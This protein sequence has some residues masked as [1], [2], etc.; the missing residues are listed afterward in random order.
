MRSFY[1]R[2]TRTPETDWDEEKGSTPLCQIIKM[3]KRRIKMNKKR[4]EFSN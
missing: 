3:Y 1:F 2:L 4:L